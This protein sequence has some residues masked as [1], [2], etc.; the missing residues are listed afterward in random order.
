MRALHL[1]GRFAFG[2]LALVAGCAPPSVNVPTNP[3][4]YPQVGTS[5]RAKSVTNQLPCDS[6]QHNRPFSD[7]AG[8]GNRGGSCITSRT[9]QP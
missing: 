5:A 6:L 4:P 7:S 2:S 1:I 3:H 8:G 9:G